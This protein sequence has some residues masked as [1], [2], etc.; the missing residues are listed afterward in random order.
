MSFR[1]VGHGAPGTFQLNGEK[2]NAAHFANRHFVSRLQSL[3]EAAPCV[4][5]L[6]CRV[7]LGDVGRDF[8]RT[9][10]RAVGKPVFA[11]SKY[12]GPASLGGTY[13]LDFG[14]CP[15]TNKD[16]DGY[17]AA[18]VE[19]LNHLLPVLTV[20]FDAGYIGKRG[21]NNQKNNDVN[22]FANMN[23]DKAYFSQ[24]STT[25]QFQNRSAFGEAQGNDVPGTLTIESGGQTFEIPGYIGWQDKLGGV[26]QSFGFLPSDN[27]TLNPDPSP[28]IMFQQYN[29]NGTIDGSAIEW[30]AYGEDVTDNESLNYPWIS[31]V[32]LVL[33]GADAT[34]VAE[35]YGVS[36]PGNDV[37]GSADLK[38]VLNKL[39]EYLNYVQTLQPQ[40]DVT[41]ESQG[42]TDTTPTLTGTVVLDR[43][44]N[45]EL[46]VTVNGVLYTEADAALVV[47]VGNNTWS[48]TIPDGQD[49]DPGIY[50]VTATTIDTDTGLS[51]SDN[52]S[53]ELVVLGANEVFVDSVTVNE[54]S[55]Y[56]IFTAFASVGVSL[57]LASASGVSSDNAVKGTDFGTAIEYWN[58][59]AWDTYSSAVPVDA[60]GKLFFR[61]PIIN[62][63]A[64]PVF[65]GNEEYTVTVTDAANSSYTATGV[66]IIE[67]S[68]YAA[69]YA[70]GDP[71]PSEDTSVTRDQDASISVSDVTVFEDAAASG[72]GA[73]FAITSSE[74]SANEITLAYSDGD[75]PLA[76]AYNPDD[77]TAAFDFG[78]KWKNADGGYLNWQI[79][80]T[81]GTWNDY[82]ESALPAITS[83]QTLYVRVKIENDAIADDGETFKLQASYAAHP[84]ITDEGLATIND[85][86]DSNTVGLTVDSITVNEGSDWAVFTITNASGAG[87]TVTDLAFLDGD[88]AG[89]TSTSGLSGGTAEFYDSSTSSWTTLPSAGYTVPDDSTLLV[90]TSIIPEQ[91]TPLDNNELFRLVT[92]LDTGE[93]LVGAGTITDDGT[94]NLY[95]DAGPDSDGN[96]TLDVVTTPDNDVTLTVNDIDVNEGSPG[97]AVFTVTALPG[98]TLTLSVSDGGGSAGSVDAIGADTPT[99][100]DG[101]E[102]YSN[103]IE[104]FNG[105]W[106]PYTSGVTVDNTG[107]LYVRLGLV[108]DSNSEGD[109]YFELTVTDTDL[110]LSET[111][112]AKILDDGTGILV[113]NDTAP[114]VADTTTV[115][116]DDSAFSVSDIVV[117]EASPYAV[118]TISGAQGTTISGLTLTD[119]DSSGNNVT[120]NLSDNELEYF[121]GT[122]WEVFSSTNPITIDATATLLVRI[123]IAEEQDSFVD[124]GEK[125]QLTVTKAD[126]GSV[127]GEATINDSG[128]GTKFTGQADTGTSPPT[129]STEGTDLDFDTDVVS[130]ND[131]IVNEASD[132]AINIISGANN[133]VLTSM[134]VQDTNNE[135]VIQNFDLKVFD[136]ANYNPSDPDSAWIDFVPNT[137]PLNEF[138]MLAVRTTIME[139]QDVERDNGE[140]F[141]LTVN[142]TGTVTIVDDGTGAI[143]TGAIDPVSGLP[144][145]STTG[146]DNDIP[147]TSSSTSSYDLCGW[148]A[149]E[150]QTGDTSYIHFTSDIFNTDII[151]R[152]ADDGS[153]DLI[154]F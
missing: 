91:D 103:T 80:G 102:D 2:I 44:E 41:V 19:G 17:Q 60:D 67:D 96:P 58:G 55:P 94:G 37:G 10:A 123:S 23:I 145:T 87:Q 49:L 89:G 25:D 97:G 121:N 76:T 32:G 104:Y 54:A 82:D 136:Y 45:E 39:N 61:V 116:D 115:P 21:T 24:V 106:T 153:A 83:S 78:E 151:M 40:G 56:A 51:S 90:R 144:T 147:V 31:N 1:F 14:Y 140:T 72:D 81:S 63:T 20:P 84:A 50:D 139:E 132:Y 141:Q 71:P 35:E 27:F 154:S 33:Y 92:T 34:H 68:G 129:P 119:G 88:G 134:T 149:R 64:T 52:T 93:L 9:F 86:N 100:T 137:T 130:I 28:D 125:F 42:T 131:V 112:L 77:P 113:Q 74:D 30:V 69:V 111:G 110:A 126:G 108:N 146:L 5:L 4:E 152:F 6:S 48:L 62:D 22:S 16:L 114:P 133:L 122:T 118:F 57:E 124:D 8:V 148:D 79:D 70:D 18:P 26:S 128:G 65:E 46:T 75:T 29:Q 143:F 47:D 117:N 95:A 53:A 7:A 38:D 11:S 127:T 142:P 109:E 150:Y 59:A 98:N 12:V 105:S 107:I 66:G 101:S 15:K 43:A 36:V 73:V 13:V 85:S 120:L 138:G 99:A 3:V 135:V